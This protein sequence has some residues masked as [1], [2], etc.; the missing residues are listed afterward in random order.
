MENWISTVAALFLF[1]GLAAGYWIGHRSGMVAGELNAIKKRR[2]E[3]FHRRTAH[4]RP[5][6]DRPSHETPS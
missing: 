3:Q 5:L 6:I 4:R 1:V 2:S